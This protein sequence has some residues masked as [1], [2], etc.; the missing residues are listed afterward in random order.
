[1][2]GR[3]VIAILLAA[4]FAVLGLGIL[5]SILQRPAGS[6]AE[7]PA[8][9]SPP[10]ESPTAAATPTAS[11]EYQSTDELAVGDCYDPIEDRDDEA[12][13]AARMLDCAGLH[14]AEV[15]AISDLAGGPTS[16]FPTAELHMLA[17]SL[18]DKAYADYVG[19]A[20]EVSRYGY[21]WYGPTEDQWRAGNREIMCVI[22]NGGRPMVGSAKGLR[23]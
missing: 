17:E 9:G 14:R 11:P 19:V 2:G 15:F 7:P 20:I 13:L 8:G 6:G 18:C 5:A 16:A 10:L 1:M 21:V 12:L 23:R 4:A 3:S 22:D